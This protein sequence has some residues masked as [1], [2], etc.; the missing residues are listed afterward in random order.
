MSGMPHSFQPIILACI[1][2]LYSQIASVGALLI[3]G[4]LGVDPLSQQLVQFKVRNVPGTIGSANLSTAN[5]LNYAIWEPTNT[6]YGERDFHHVYS[7]I[8]R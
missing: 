8:Y 5:T 1:Q 6:A 4:G 3:V 7:W 2:A